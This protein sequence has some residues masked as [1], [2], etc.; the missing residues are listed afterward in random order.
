MCLI[1]CNSDTKDTEDIV[2]TDTIMNEEKYPS[3]IVKL[4]LEKWYDE[5]K[6]VMYCIYCDEICKF[7]KKTGINDSITFASLDLKFDKIEQ[8]NDSTEISFYF[9]FNDT[10]KIDLTTTRNLG[11]VSGTGFIKGRDSIF[12]Y[13]SPGTMHRFW[14]NDPTSRY[15][16]PLQPDVIEYI[17]ANENKLN[18]WFREEAKRRGV[19][20]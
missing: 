19:I 11:L 3:E 1:A 6:W 14:T 7:E 18:P 4:G 5:T 10:L 2:V 15:K 13:I 8:F 9:Y 20:K 17:K 12:F 16:N